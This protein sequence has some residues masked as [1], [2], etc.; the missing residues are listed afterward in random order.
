MLIKTDT[1]AKKSAL[2]KCANRV[3]GRKNTKHTNDSLSIGSTLASQA[4]DFFSFLTSFP[5]AF[6]CFPLLA[7]VGEDSD[8][9]GE[10]C[11]LVGDEGFPE[12]ETKRANHV[13]TSDCNSGSNP[14]CLMTDNKDR[15]AAPI[16]DPARYGVFASLVANCL[17]KGCLS[18]GCA[19]AKL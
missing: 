12:G 16:E 10:D 9:L 8:F 11:R 18:L 1:R 13:F 2:H 15:S 3:S 5:G 17:S 19:Q 6:P 7:L 4:G 14:S